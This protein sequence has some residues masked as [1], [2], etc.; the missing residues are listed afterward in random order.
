MH[1]SIITESIPDVATVADVTIL[2]NLITHMSQ[3][4][5]LLKLLDE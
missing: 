3:S 1:L 2:Y 5:T 4:S